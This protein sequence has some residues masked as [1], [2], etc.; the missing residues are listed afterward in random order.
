MSSGPSERS[1]S[2]HRRVVILLSVFALAQVGSWLFY[3][4]QQLL[5]DSSALVRP[6]FEK[7]PENLEDPSEFILPT[8]FASQLSPDAERE[9]RA[10]FAQ[11]GLMLHDERDVPP[12]QY[13]TDD[14]QH[15]LREF[16][17]TVRLNTPVLACARTHYAR[18]G[19]GATF[20]H[21]RVWLLI[22]WIPV[23]DYFF[24]SG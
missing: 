4:R 17:V 2:K 5:E 24:A 7:Y 10:T 1:T 19:A 20:N 6:V 21:W 14:G 16:S 12:D 22:G 8:A 3:G 11:L 9:L 13:K 15:V 23:W 18:L